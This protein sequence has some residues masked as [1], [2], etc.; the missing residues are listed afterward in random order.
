MIGV[1]W[2][3]TTKRA[4]IKNTGKILFPA[5]IWGGNYRALYV[6]YKKIDLNGWEKK[7]KEKKTN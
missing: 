2:L 6:R 1:T 4:V 5:E 7:V 3:I